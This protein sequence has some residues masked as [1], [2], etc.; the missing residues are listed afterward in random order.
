M[1]E[2]IPGLLLSLL[3]RYLLE[4]DEILLERVLR[5]A[6]L[7]QA[8][9][10]VAAAHYPESELQALLTAAAAELQC[11]PQALLRDAAFWAVPLLLQ[12]FDSLVAGLSEPLEFLENMGSTVY[13][14]L[15][16]MLRCN[17][18]AEY[19]YTR[20]GPQSCCISYR[21]PRQLCSIVEGGLLGLAGQLGA[22]LVIRHEQC[23]RHGDSQCQ[24]HLA[25][26]GIQA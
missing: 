8:E 21:S 18:S 20:T 6:G 25:F 17:S 5:R 2:T 24:L 23:Q 22:P 11:E 26:G 3:E 13:P 14:Q 19:G 15:C 16:R 7:D 1:M 9:P 12:R 10:W 4:R